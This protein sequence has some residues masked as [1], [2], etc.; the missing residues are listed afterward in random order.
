MQFWCDSNGFYWS[1]KHDVTKTYVHFGYIETFSWRV[2]HFLPL[3]GLLL[4]LFAFVLVNLY[5]AK[6]SYLIIL[7]HFELMYHWNFKPKSANQAHIATVVLSI[8]F[9]ERFLISTANSEIKT[10]QLSYI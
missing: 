5:S 2:L 7:L 3:V 8:L 9:R 10:I 6:I 4:E 1:Q